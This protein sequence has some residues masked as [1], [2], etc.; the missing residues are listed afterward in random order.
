M[1]TKATNKVKKLKKTKKTKTVPSTKEV[2]HKKLL[3]RI[4]HRRQDFLS[5]RPHRS[6]RWTRRRD[7]KRSL[8][9]PGYWAFTAHVCKTL[10][11]NKKMFI[12]LAVIYAALSGLLVGMASQDT[13]TTLTDTL[14][15][16]GQNIFEGAWGQVGQA[17][18]LFTTAMTGSLSQ[19]MTEVQQVYA[20]LISLL[21]WLTT[22]WL[23]RNVLAG[24]QV[25]LR[26]GIYSAGAPIVSTALVSLMLIV[27]MLPL[28]LAMIGY[29]AALSSGLL[30]GG[31]EA[32]LFWVAAGFL[33]VLSLYWITSTLIA[34]VIVTLPGM[35]PLRALKTA[36]DLVVGRRLRI[37]L[38]WL[39][40]AFVTVVVWAIVMIPIILLD[41]WLKGIW[42]AITG[43]PIIP[44]TLLIL[45]SLTI[46][47][48]SSYV[49][50]LYRKVVADDAKPA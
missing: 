42:P 11:K 40:M 25:R 43:L 23:L 47:W 10:W 7:Y 17:G 20:V 13:Y 36:G 44:V 5:R 19:E 9:L 45:S 33:A 38:R 50:L 37:L 35:Y 46:I 30:V 6:F 22:V 16:T 14:R 31:I 18:L 48:V 4:N 39:W 8:K 27:Q 2:A 29:S 15:E 34:L 3:T 26:D 32:M 1:T 41:T 21:I 24:R 12:W 28:A 49:Y